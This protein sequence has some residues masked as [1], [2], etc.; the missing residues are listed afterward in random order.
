MNDN[1]PFLALPPRVQFS[2]QL[3]YRANERQG[4]FAPRFY[5]ELPNYPLYLGVAVLKEKNR[6]SSYALSTPRHV[7]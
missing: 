4:V 2:C 6:M 1:W 5:L 3:H 7:L